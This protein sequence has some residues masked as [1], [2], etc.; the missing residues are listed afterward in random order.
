MAASPL[1]SL[2]DANGDPVQTPPGRRGTDGPAGWPAP[3]RADRPGVI[4]PP[5]YRDEIM[6]VINLHEF[7]DAAKKSLSVAAYDYVA[8]GAGDELTLRANREAFRHY[9]IRRKVMV[10]VSK[11]DT[12]FELLG[13][14]L[15][16]PILLG[17]GGGKN[18]VVA[19]GERLAAQAARQSKALMVGG[20]GPMLAEMG[21]AG[22]APIW[23]GA[24]LG[25]GTQAAAVEY[26]KRAK[27][28]GASALCI[29]VDYPYTGARDRPSRDQW[30][31]E[32]ART[33]V[34]GTPGIPRR[35][36]GRHARSLHAEPDV[37]VDEV[38]ASGDQAADRD[39]RHPDRRRR[40]ARRRARRAGDHR[41]ESRRADARRHGGHARSRLPEVVEAVN[42]KI[43]VLVDGGIRRGG[44]VIKALALGAK[45]I[46]I[47]RPFLWGLAAFGQDG[48]Q[49]VVELLH[50]ELR[51]ALGLSGAGSL[52]AI[53][54]SFIRP[55][56]KAVQAGSLT[57]TRWPRDR[58][59]ASRESNHRSPGPFDP[60]EAT[61]QAMRRFEAQ[62]R[63]GRR[64]FLSTLALLAGAAPLAAQEL[65][66]RTPRTTFPPQHSP[67][68]ME[69]VNVHE[70]QAIAAKNV[71]QAVYDYASGGS[72]DDYTLLGNLEAFRANAA[73]PARDGR[74]QQDRHVAR[75]PGT[76]AAFPIMLAPA[77]KNR[78][79]PQG[80]KVAAIGAHGAK[81]HLRHR[82]QRA[83]LH[84]GSHQGRP[85]A[86]L[87]G[88]HA[89]PHDTRQTRRTGR[90]ATKKPAPPG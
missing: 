39:E 68:V 11:V 79:V 15:E 8:A 38:G 49:R 1:M 5:A 81:A 47:G 50:G 34:Y 43:P 64:E 35:I 33:R 41:L 18:I 9:W 74:R 12:S 69:P 51:I 14:T 67:K 80:D 54:R 30:D 59:A 87:D 4:R 53:D 19:D 36:P 17:P 75:G 31:P 40:A 6:K 60:G 88:Q 77:S 25:E 45:A 85:G 78:V 48:V 26:A 62:G 73:A 58:R 65:V 55:A 29:T 2:V 24:T 27:D 52:K 89:R 10:D 76:E 46:L 86:D 20:Q 66:P 32:W 71:S 84:R 57:E 61:L 23:W 13:Q 63:K 90:G 72:E 70:I 37:G 56:W 28:N 42:G 44:D 3:A 83:R 16:H 22:Q 21:K 7:E 82:R